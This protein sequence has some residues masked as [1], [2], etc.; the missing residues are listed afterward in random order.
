MPFHVAFRFLDVTLQRRV[1]SA[2]SSPVALTGLGHAFVHWYYGGPLPWPLPWLSC[3]I[4]DLQFWLIGSFCGVILYRWFEQLLVVI[5]QFGV[6]RLVELLMPT[7]W[8]GSGMRF[9]RGLLI[10]LCFFFFFLS[11]VGTLHVVVKDG[12]RRRPPKCWVYCTVPRSFANHAWVGV[13]VWWCVCL[14]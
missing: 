8:I 5:L 11:G 4:V 2:N 10:A 13:M 7:K 12:W 1:L 9:K 3:L 6:W 14:V